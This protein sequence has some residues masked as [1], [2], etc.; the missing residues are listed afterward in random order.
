MDGYTRCSKK[1]VPPPLMCPTI[2]QLMNN[3]EF[4]QVSAHDN[5]FELQSIV[6][7]THFVVSGGK[8]HTMKPYG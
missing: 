3:R 2:V 6:I 1:L 4:V 7:V 5:K 8:I